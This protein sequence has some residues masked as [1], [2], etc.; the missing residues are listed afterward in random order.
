MVFFL[1]LMVVKLINSLDYTM[2]L[3]LKLLL[4]PLV[5]AAIGWITNKIAVWLLFNPKEPVKILFWTFQG[6][7]PK[8]QSMIAARIGDLVAD[9]LLSTQSIKEQVFTDE[10]LS[11]I[12]NFIL[13]RVDL[14]L[15]DEF[16]K[17]HW[18][19]NMFMGDGTKTKMKAELERKLYESLDD[20]SANFHHYLEDKVNIRKLV[21]DRINGLDSAQV[22]G[23]MNQILK[24]EL[25]FIEL[26]GAILG[27]LIG[28]IQVLLLEIIG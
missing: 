6:V 23:L 22:N 12:V 28:L 24:S 19:L 7:F 11:G 20:I 21:S 17:E 26:T 8:R 15:E 3:L 10:N 14:Y 16:K 18:F 4:I 25:S 5:S 13:H 27:F 1:L 9:E 2:I